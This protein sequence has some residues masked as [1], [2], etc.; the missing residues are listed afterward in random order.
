MEIC[1]QL[2]CTVIHP[3]WQ[4]LH[5]QALACVDPEYLAMLARDDVW[6]PGPENIFNAFSIDQ[7][8]V[9]YILFGES[10]YPRPESA[11]G[12]AF[13]DASVDGLWSTNGLSKRVNR[14][15]S[16]RN[17]LKMLLLARGDLEAGRLS[18]QDI[19]TVDK[20]HLIKDI[21]ELFHHMLEHGFMLLNASLT[22]THLGARKDARYWQPFIATMLQELAKQRPDIELILFGNIAKTINALPGTEAFAQFHCEHPYNI[23]FITNQAVLDFFRPF[24]LLLRRDSL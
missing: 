12:F 15:T 19:A 20:I 17:L 7:D 8:Q 18:Q 22:L 16:L 21:S 5:Q 3:S 4:A 11:N 10:P 13:W 2:N 14:A 1:S 23:S 9:R 24:D 6:L